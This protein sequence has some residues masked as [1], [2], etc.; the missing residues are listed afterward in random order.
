MLTWT[1]PDSGRARNPRST[2][3]AVFRGQAGRSITG[4]Q[5][6][7]ELVDGASPP[8]GLIV[9]PLV[10]HPQ[11]AGVFIVDEGLAAAS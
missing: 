10:Q 2:V 11:C 6:R 8:G 7:I 9:S 3:A 4:T 5:Q 1:R